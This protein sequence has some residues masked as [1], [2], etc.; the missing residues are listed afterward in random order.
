MV[1]DH[2]SELSVD[3]YIFK[4]KNSFFYGTNHLWF[5]YNDYEVTIGLSD[6]LQQTIGDIAFLSFPKIGSEIKQNIPCIEIETIKVNH[7]ISFSFNGTVLDVNDELVDSP[8]IVNND[9]YDKGW[10]VKIKINDTD[11]IKK[12]QMSSEQYIEFVK[13]EIDKS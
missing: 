4:I 1:T 2:Y 7:E 10:L 12:S 11:L 9:P 3:K 5:D 6:Y 8:E 13:N